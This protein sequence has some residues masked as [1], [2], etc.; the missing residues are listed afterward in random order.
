MEEEVD[1]VHQ[2]LH[3]DMKADRQLERLA[4]VQTLTEIIHYYREKRARSS[5]IALA[6]VK[7][8]KEG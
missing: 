6:I 7:F 4:D 3:A 1:E 2:L 8:V 5:E